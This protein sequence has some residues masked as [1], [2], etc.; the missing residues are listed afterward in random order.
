VSILLYAAQNLVQP[1][2][3]V[4]LDYLQR[5]SGRI[6]HCRLPATLVRQATYYAYAVEGPFDL[7]QGHRFDPE[8]VLIDPYAQTLFFPPGFD[9]DASKGHG[10]N[11]GKTPL[12][13]IPLL[14]AP[15]DWGEERR[16]RHTSDTIIYE[17]HIKG[18]TRRANSG[19]SSDKRGT[20][21]GV[22]EKIPYLQELGVTV[23][24]LLPVYQYDPEDGGNYWGYM[25]LNFFAP[26][27]RYARTDV[28]AE[29][30]DEFRTMVKAFHDAGIEVVLDVDT[31]IPPNKMSR[32]R[33]TAIAVS[34]IAPTTCWT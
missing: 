16:L 25:P 9:R 29:R 18:L 13:E 30:A 10:S 6:W 15:F 8:K 32:D 26:H 11:A 7:A 19:V 14:R 22:I 21:A 5:K 4:R 34:I 1:L 28:P 12:G 3:S 27:H 23:V 33:P 24:E 17:M 20:Y 2:V 31:T